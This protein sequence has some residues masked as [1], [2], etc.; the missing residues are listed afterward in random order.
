LRS[1]RAVEQRRQDRISLLA[2]GF[3]IIY[4]IFSWIPIKILGEI[5]FGD[6]RL[7]LALPAA[8]IAFGFW[9]ILS[10]TADH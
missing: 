7:D 3:L 1:G 5:Q 10:L 8:V 6:I 2:F 4:N 9:V